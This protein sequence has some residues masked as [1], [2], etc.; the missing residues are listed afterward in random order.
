MSRAPVSRARRS[1]LVALVAL[2]AA[3]A[4][5]AAQVPAD[6]DWTEHTIG[7][8]A[9][10]PAG[11]PALHADLFLPR[12]LPAGERLPVVVS[13]GPYFGHSGQDAVHP[14]PT[15]TGPR[16]RWRDLLVDGRLLQRG[17]ALVQVHL[18]GTGGSQGCN[19]FGGAGEQRDVKRA[20]EWAAAQPWSNGRVVVYGKSYDAWTGVMALDERP[21]GLTAAVIMSPVAEGYNAL[22]Q[23]GLHYEFGNWTLPAVYQAGDAL[24]PTPDDVREARTAYLTGAVTGLDPACYARNIAL[25]NGL[26]ERDDALGFWRERRHPGAQGSTVPTFFG[27][28]FVDTLAK[29][30]N[31]L[32]V[33]S[34]LAGPK[35]AWFGQFAHTRLNEPGV[36]R[37][38]HF[39][40]ELFA[41]L[42]E[43]VKGAPAAGLPPVE[44][45]DSLGRWRAE[46]AWPP[47][48]SQDRRVALRPGT[49]RDVSR[50]KNLNPPADGGSVWSITAP[51]PHEAWV[52]GALS[53][54]VD[55]TAVARAAVVVRVWDVDPDGFGSLLTMGGG[56]L[57]AGGATTKRVELW[58]AD[59]V[60]R[61][62]HRIAIEV[63]GGD[64]LFLQPFTGEEVAVRG[65]ALTLPF[66]RFDRT[67]FLP[68]APSR[69]AVGRRRRIIPA[70]VLEGPV[71]TFDPPP[72]LEG[73]P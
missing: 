38:E 36:G 61:A 72:P 43:H 42:D 32:P 39:F 1:A 13:V 27:F 16:V 22:Y 48:D 62:E 19:D 21:R 24:P 46:A 68:G 71:T 52:S 55:V 9:P 67:R 49:Y 10:Y 34:A 33:W 18:R 56:R 59:H 64:P 23:D 7:G 5:A 51:L 44:V 15:A 11:E 50:E 12:G 29:P 26:Q 58:P 3:A 4:P 54:A 69:E 17:Y 40:E 57:A 6:A 53:A 66:L 28:G 8:G 35:R 70:A 60:V 37:H 65:G 47:A 14:E 31:L 20:I 73:R 2:L 30:D 45:E 41:F 63:A 25:Q